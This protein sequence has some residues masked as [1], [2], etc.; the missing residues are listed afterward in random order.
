MIPK[1]YQLPFG[2]WT[3]FYSEVVGTAQQTRV[4]PTVQTFGDSPARLH[5]EHPERASKDRA[6]PG[7]F[8]AAFRARQLD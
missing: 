1:F 4:K 8:D 6:M 5:S 7:A 3:A 2:K